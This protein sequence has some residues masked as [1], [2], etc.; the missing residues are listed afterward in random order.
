MNEEKKTTITVTVEDGKELKCVLKEPDFKTYCH[1]LNILNQQ[2]EDGSIK[3]LEAGDVILINCLIPE[4]S[5]NL[6]L[7]RA[8]VRVLACQAATSMLRIWSVDIK[9]N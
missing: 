6:I 7:T 5:D 1:A 4:E 8:D 3:L 2:N 9:K